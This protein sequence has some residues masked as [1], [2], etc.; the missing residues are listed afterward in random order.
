MVHCEKCGTLPVKE[1]DLPVQL[2]ENIKFTDDG[3]SPLKA[4]TVS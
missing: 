2:P 4:V 3:K 1:Q